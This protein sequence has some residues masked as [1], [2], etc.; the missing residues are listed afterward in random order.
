L[1]DGYTGGAPFTYNRARPAFITDLEIAY[2]V[3]PQLTFTLGADNL[4]DKYAAHTTAY[5]R[6]QNAEQYILASPYG[7]DG[8][9]Y[10]A[11]AAYKF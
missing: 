4:F 1:A 9:Y 2:K 6:Y 7:I 5:A 11:R 10:Y 3:T 8:G